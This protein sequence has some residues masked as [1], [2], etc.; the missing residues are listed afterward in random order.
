MVTNIEHRRMIT[1]LRIGCS[2]LRTHVFLS[3]GESD[4]CKFCPD[5]SENLKHFITECTEYNVDRHKFYDNI[6]TIGINF[7]Y[8][9]VDAILNCILN[10]TPPGTFNNDKRSKF[11][12]YCI[13]YICCLYKHRFSDQ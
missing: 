2:K 4:V 6:E 7:Q 8:F 12:T 10:L 11:E 1:K 9:P 13:N 3:K 5:K